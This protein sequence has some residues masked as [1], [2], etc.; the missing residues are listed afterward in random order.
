LAKQTT[1]LTNTPQTMEELLASQPQKT[2]LDLTRGQEIEGEVILITDKEITLDLGAKSEGIIPIRDFDSS[3]T[4][5]GDRIKGFVVESENESHQIVLSMARS[6]RVA[7]DGK[8][9]RPESNLDFEKINQ[10]YADQIVKGTVTKV[11]QFGVFVQ[12]EEGLEGLIH[13]S[14]LGPDDDFKSG[15]SISVSVDSVDTD[16]KRVALSPV[17]T[18]TKGLIYK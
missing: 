11:T 9:V 13:I 12:L 8:R 10:K 5:V 15:D 7:P 14:K 4:K 17:I 16:K 1:N 3:K 6:N 2:T 18:S